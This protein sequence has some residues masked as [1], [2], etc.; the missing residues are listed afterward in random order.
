MT[1][2]ATLDLMLQDLA[3][4]DALHRPTSFWQ[5]AS[6][7]ISE[8]LRTHGVEK[9]R[10]LP[11]PLGYFVPTYGLPGNSFDTE[12]VVDLLETVSNRFSNGSKQELTLR[13][14][15]SGEQ[16]AL[17]DFRTYLAGDDT[18]RPPIL[19]H[20]SECDAGEPVEQFT[21]SG[22]RFSRSML[23]YMLVLVFLKKHVD[24]TNL[25]HV[26][27]VGG[28]FGSLG[29]ILASDPRNTYTYVDID[30]PPTA[31]AANYYLKCIFGEKLLEYPQSRER[32]PIF[33]DGTFDAAVLCPWQLPDLQGQFDLFVNAISFQEMEPAVVRYYLEHVNRL[34]TR[35]VLL[36][37]LREGK[38]KKSEA[39]AVGVEEP[40][41]GGDYDSF[42]PGYDL[43]AVNTI[44]FGYRT[45]DGFHSEVRLYRRRS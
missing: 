3:D 2:I 20:C 30:I 24:T 7:A 26:L 44:P 29:E 25:K 12:L 18:T 38:Q 10:S 41:L 6:L 17:G 28:G 37:N 11:G 5:E 45:V 42:L 4:Q 27:E 9:F 36:R 22:R 14:L 34:E 39:G 13:Q 1:D 15:L 33:P 19:S 21:F 43:V 23:N 8:E 32:R 40:I 31:A 16:H 35:F